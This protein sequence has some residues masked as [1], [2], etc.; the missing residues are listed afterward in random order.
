[1]ISTRKN[2]LSIE[3]MKQKQTFT[4]KIIS[5]AGKAAF[6]TRLDWVIEQCTAK[7]GFAP[8]PGT[9]NI[10]I[11]PESIIRAETLQ[12]GEI[13]DLCSPD[14]A[15]CASQVVPVLLEGIPAAVIIPEEKVRIHGRDIIEILAPVNL[16]EVLQ[17][18][19]G[20][21]VSGTMGSESDRRVEGLARPFQKIEV[22][23]IMLD[24]DGTIIDSIEIYYS[25]VRAVLDQL[26]LPG[27]SNRQIQKA[28]ENGSFHWEMLFPPERVGD[29]AGMSE[30]AWAIAKQISPG[31]F[32]D[33]V[34]LLPGA[35]EVLK[36]IS[37]K[38]FKLAV[39]T[40]TPQQNMAAK[41]KPL[42]ESG[43]LHLLQEII[44]A[45]DTIRKK[46]AA[47]PLLECSQRL[48]IEAEKCVYAGDTQLDIRAGK[49]AGTRTIGVLTGFD[50]YETLKEEKPDA[51]IESLA[52]LPEVVLM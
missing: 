16:R 38:G 46:P 33:R 27:V 37:A 13:I 31:M 19:D 1:M 14:P 32:N 5:G 23:A 4:G 6:F 47:D 30:K 20:D 7:L 2:G 11:L 42:A 25:I 12:T 40:S 18:E 28:N 45:D 41:L 26:H 10:E 44:T 48:A 21:L 9:L 49:A 35:A 17:K 51:I 50:S 8:F 3:L 52:H 24:L 43:T 15:N 39:V 34:K 29:H 36:R 22:E